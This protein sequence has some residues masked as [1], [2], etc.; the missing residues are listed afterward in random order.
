[1]LLLE[2][3]LAFPD[4]APLLEQV[5]AALRPGGRFALTVEAGSPLTPAER[6]A[7]PAADTVWPVPLPDLL[8]GLDR[9]GLQVT[10]TEDVTL[11]HRA[12]A[13]ALAD[14]FVADRS[15]I[16]RRIGREALDE[17]VAAHLLWSTWFGNGRVQKCAVVATKTRP[18]VDG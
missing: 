15:A 18:S 10:W 13:T 12:T 8:A 17:L 3:L 7:M 9:A 14:A 2:T 16:S 6:A 1:V 5:A 11:A 4:K